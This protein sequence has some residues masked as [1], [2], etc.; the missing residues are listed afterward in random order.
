MQFINGGS[1]PFCNYRQDDPAHFFIH[2][3]QWSTQRLALMTDGSIIQ[4]TLCRCNC[5]QKVTFSPVSRAEVNTGSYIWKLIFLAM[6]A[7]LRS[8]M[9]LFLAAQTF[10]EATDTVDH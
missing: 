6:A 8:R 3:A 1:C 5:V 4:N 2:C 7:Y 9:L 10:I